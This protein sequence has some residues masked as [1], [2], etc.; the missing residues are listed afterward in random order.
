MTVSFLGFISSVF[1][2]FTGVLFGFALAQY[3]HAREER[4]RLIKQADD[5]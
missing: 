1:L 2:Y 4:D 5:K 3:L